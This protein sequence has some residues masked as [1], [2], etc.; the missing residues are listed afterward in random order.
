MESRFNQLIIEELKKQKLSPSHDLFHIEQVLQYAEKLQNIQGGDWDII[1]ASVLLHDLE[2][3]SPKIIYK[4]NIENLL[5][6]VSKIL[7][8]VGFTFEKVEK[9]LE[10]IEDHEKKE[11]SPRSLEG[12]ILKDADFLA[13]FGAWGILRIAMWLGETGGGVSNFL[14]TIDIKMHKRIEE[15]EFVESKKSARKKYVFAKLFIS[16]LQ[17]EPELQKPYPGK[18]IILEGNGGVG[19]TTQS[20][21]LTKRLMLEGKRSKKVQE[22]SSF[23]RKIETLWEDV[24]KETLKDEGTL[25]RR[26]L[27][28]GDRDRIIKEKIL[29]AL[30]DGCFVISDR[31]YISMLVYQCENEVDRL[32]TSFVHSFLPTPDLIIFYDA[33][34]NICYERMKDRNLIGPFDTMEDLVKYRPLYLEAAKED[35]YGCPVEVIDS[36]G[37]IENV[38]EETWQVLIENNLI[39]SQT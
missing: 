27:M 33:D 15:L 19:K 11:L 31:S 32:F 2:R 34:E 36:T 16:F 4:L 38:A 22:P 23:F 30:Q 13:G 9:V 7:E 8:K 5:G 28:I 10:A 35:Y 37:T 29:P 21:I 24:Y 14:D 25:F 17:E 26:Y 20:E 3:A 39:D 18:Y 6:K 1:S 12:R